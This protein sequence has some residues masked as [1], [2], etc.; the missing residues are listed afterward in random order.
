EEEASQGRRGQ[1]GQ[2]WHD[3]P[4]PGR[5]DPG[6]RGLRLE[7]PLRAQGVP[8][9]GAGSGA[10]WIARG[11]ASCL[12]LVD[13]TSGATSPRQGRHNSATVLAPPSRRSVA[14]LI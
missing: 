5:R 9:L 4:E 12:L 6:P 11:D 13:L 1:G 7:L 8:R 3:N 2:G 14:R 10:E